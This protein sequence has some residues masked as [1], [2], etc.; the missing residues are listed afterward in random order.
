MGRVE[1]RGEGSCM[2]E[3]KIQKIGDSLGV[4]LPPEL[5]ALLH[6]GEGQILFVNESG[7]GDLRLS[8]SAPG[9]MDKMAVARDIASRYRKT[10]T[11]LSK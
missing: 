10:L 4:I 1:W 8:A 3:L 9:R 11:A 7:D 6:R 5:L 2:V